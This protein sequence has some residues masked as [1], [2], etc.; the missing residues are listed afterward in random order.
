MGHTAAHEFTLWGWAHSVCIRACRCLCLS[1]LLSRTVCVCA[2]A[3]VTNLCAM[4]DPK[5]HSISYFEAA[6]TLS[7]FLCAGGPARAPVVGQ[8]VHSLDI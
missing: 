2:A 4:W 7:A 8:T 5:L 3:D 6:V 1:W